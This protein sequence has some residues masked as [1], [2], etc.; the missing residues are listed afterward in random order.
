M[1]LGVMIF[2][3]DQTIQPTKLGVEAEAR[4]FES[5]W[6]PEHSHIPV[7]QA[8]PWG[9]RAGAGP[10]PNFYSRTHDQF[11][12]LGAVAAVTNKIKLGTGITLLAQRDVVWTAK[13][14]ASVDHISDGRLLFG[15]GYGGNKEEMKTQFTN[16]VKL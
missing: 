11:V 6:F 16:R 7:S 14:A 13:A 5:L 12:A 3:T 2:P 8:T 4:G 15:I 10:A 9:G 1:D